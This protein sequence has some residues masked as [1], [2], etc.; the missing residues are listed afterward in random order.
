MN[1]R[2]Y[3]AFDAVQ[4]DEALKA[5]TVAAVTE[6]LQARRPHPVRRWAAVA[7]CVLVLAGFGG[8]RVYATPTATV[9]IDLPQTVELEVNRFGRVVEATGTDAA[10]CHQTYEAALTVLFEDLGEGVLPWLWTA[11]QPSAPLFP[12]QWNAAPADGP[13]A[14]AGVTQ[15]M[16][17]VKLRA[18]TTATDGSTVTGKPS[19]GLH[20]RSNCGI[21]KKTNRA[22]TYNPADLARESLQSRPRLFYVCPTGQRYARRAHILF[23]HL[24]GGLHNDSARNHRNDHR[25]GKTD[26]PARRLPAAG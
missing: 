25:A 18:A 9:R 6:R 24:K 8:Y 16:K 13:I 4:A 23:F 15:T 2:I 1:E 19:D 5:K 11:I 7:A 14:T 17:T 3:Q 12:T 20:L 26:L 21:L 10:V 22:Y